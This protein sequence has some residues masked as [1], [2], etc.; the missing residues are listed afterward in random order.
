MHSRPK[1]RREA[2][3]DASGMTVAD[4]DLMIWKKYAKRKAA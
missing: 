1:Q 4:Y 2:L 3:A